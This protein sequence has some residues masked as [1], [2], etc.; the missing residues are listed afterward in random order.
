M[1]QTLSQAEHTF[2]NSP[3]PDDVTI[4]RP[5]SVAHILAGWQVPVPLIETV[6]W[7]AA[8][9]RGNRERFLSILDEDRAGLLPTSLV[10]WACLQNAATVEISAK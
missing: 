4:T 2:H 5:T 1:R 3:L 6:V 10:L 7:S 9:Y 8:L